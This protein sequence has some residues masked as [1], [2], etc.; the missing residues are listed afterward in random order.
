[1]LAHQLLESLERHHFAKSEV[2]CFRPGLYAEGFGRFIRQPCVEPDRGERYGRVTPMGPGCHIYLLY[3]T[4][5]RVFHFVAGLARL[6]RLDGKGPPHHGAD[7]LD[8]GQFAR[9]HRLHQ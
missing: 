4:Y 2:H 3:Q 8:P 6:E 5:I 9:A 1:M 7:L